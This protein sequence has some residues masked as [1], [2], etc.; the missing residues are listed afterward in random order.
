MKISLA[1]LKELVATDLSPE[2][3]ARAL[4]MGGLEVEEIE[5][6]APGFTGIVVAHVK[7]VAPHPNA[8]K[9]RVTEVDAGTGET[10]QIVC[11]AP[12]VAAGQKV[13]C[14]LVGA[15]L[16][17]LEIKRAKLRGVESAGMLCSAREL[18]LSDDHAGLLVLDGDAP[19][20]RDVREVLALDDVYFTLKLT[21]NR[22]DCQS[23]FGVA[24][25]VAAITGARLTLPPAPAGFS[26]R[27]AEKRAVA[28]SEPK[29]CGRYFGRVIRGID[30][31]AKTPQWMVRRIERSGLRAISPLVDITNYVMLERGQPMHAFDNAKLSGTIDVRFMKPGETVK[32]LNDQVVEYR[33][34]LLAIT[35]AKGPV[36]LGGVM[37][38]HESM[39]GAST[40]E[41]FFEAAFFHPE[42]IQG[43]ARE[44]QLTSDAAHRFERGVDPEG[45]AAALARATALTLEIC[46]GEAGPV[47]H[48]QGTPPARSAVTVRPA[49]VRELLGYGVDPSEM[50]AILERLGC[51]PQPKGDALV[52]TAPSWRFDLAIEEDYVEE[53]AR[54]HGYDHV[55]A[56]APRS[57][58]PMLRMHEGERDRF[59]LRHAMAA[60]G[61][62]EVISYSFV[63]GIWE[64]DFAGNDAPVR[65]ANPISSQMG[66]M[67]TTLLGGLVQALRANLNRGE[68]RVRVFEI[69]RC[70][71]GSAADI[72]VQPERIA[73]LAL[74][75]RLPEQWAEK[76]AGVDFYDAK[77]DLEALAATTTLEFTAGSH[78]ACHPG[79]CA[80]VA[81]AGRPVGVVGELHP[82]LQQAY[83]LPS[84]AVFFEV[85]AQ[86]LLEGLVPRFR[87][88]SRMPVVR[89]DLALLVAETVPVGELLGAV[90]GRVPAFV[91]AVEVFDQYRGKG[92]E[93]GKKSLALRIVMQD[94]DRTLT[95]SEVEG[96]VASIRE[97]LI[98]QFQAK[99]RT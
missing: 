79:R 26:E 75:S 73:A 25:D 21:P 12:N 94:T 55:P 17:G 6:V 88:L 56:I 50:R 81:A 11:G 85:L 22:G 40:T 1:W 93:P 72:A 99:P 64:H 35:D 31:A 10:L 48:A 84:A 4:T 97:Q 39:V 59:D 67:R 19:V 28:I 92:V 37:G 95:D 8:D 46:G 71:E 3:L 98:Q 49:R 20:G 86:P 83:E 24:R 51:S 69:G 65:L 52:A 15:K 77:G 42:A 54:I 62:Q 78:P 61:Y 80:V 9:L 76:S 60:R 82:R 44:L 14:A 74:G 16:P 53:V 91:R 66:V 68:D 5:R 43:K 57:S 33:P 30:A 41:V 2:A 47:T 45:A 89:R 96:V 90:R 7:S 58:V 38:G 70:F 32:L 23:M 18:G 87:G 34:D 27:I 36:G 29:A 13:P 63:S